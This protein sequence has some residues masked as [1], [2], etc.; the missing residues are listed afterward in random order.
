MK[1][2]FL[3]RVSSGPLSSEGEWRTQVC[4]HLLSSCLLTPRVAFICVMLNLNYTM[5]FFF[6]KF[7]FYACFVLHQDALYR[8]GCP[9]THCINQAGLEHIEIPLPLPSEG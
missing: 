1:A 9:G 4:F 2:P 5:T 7:N 6:T 8:P 3:P